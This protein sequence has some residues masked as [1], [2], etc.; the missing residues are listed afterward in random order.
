[1]NVKQPYTLDNGL[2]FAETATVQEVADTVGIPGDKTFL[3]EI[4]YSRDIYAKGKGLV[5][6][7]FHH[8]TWQPPN[9]ICS[10]GCFENNS[11]GI[12]LRYLNSNR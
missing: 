11:Y 8:E 6:R 10:A 9:I 5:Y 7:E 3:W 2:A 12:R 1:M 4:N